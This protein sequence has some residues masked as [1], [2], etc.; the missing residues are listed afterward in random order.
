MIFFFH[1]EQSSN[2]GVNRNYLEMNI[3]LAQSIRWIYPDVKIVGFNLKKIKL[4]Q[5]M[6]DKLH[7][8]KVDIIEEPLFDDK[9]EDQYFLRNY[10]KYYA[11][12]VYFNIYEKDLNLIYLDIDAILLKE[13]DDKYF[14]QKSII[15]EEVPLF[16]KINEVQHLMPN[17]EIKDNLYYNWFQIINKSN[18]HIYKTLP[19][20]DYSGKFTDCEMSSII[21][22][23]NLM[24]IQNDEPYYPKKEI[25]QSSCLLHY[26]SFTSEGS[27]IFLKESNYLMYIKIISFLKLLD[28]DVSTNIEYWDNYE[29]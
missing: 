16:I 29:K 7:N 18:Y 22:N 1:I 20:M 26:D 25:I 5:Y 10:V 24:I 14:Q 3:L 11:S 8:L 12:H 15:V 6:I 4:K 17:F 23:S 9:E 19:E 28:V 27:L 2:D 13:I 21:D